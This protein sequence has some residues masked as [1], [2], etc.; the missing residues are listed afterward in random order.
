[1][2]NNMQDYM[3]QQQGTKQQTS[4]PGKDSPE[5]TAGDYIDFEEVK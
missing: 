2:H 3:N 5:K 1:M 4:T